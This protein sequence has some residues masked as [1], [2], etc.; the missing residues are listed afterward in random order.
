[1]DFPK[2]TEVTK[3]KLSM[4]QLHQARVAG[5]HNPLQSEDEVNA[6]ICVHEIDRR[7][8]I[9]VVPSNNQ[10]EANSPS[11]SFNLKGHL[12]RSQSAGM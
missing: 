12:G 8:F 7:Q 4:Q 3:Q 10:S 11:N 2:K 1:M 6:D 5:V 9:F